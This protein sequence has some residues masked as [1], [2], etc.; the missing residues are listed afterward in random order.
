MDYRDAFVMVPSSFVP[1]TRENR[2]V[3]VVE[4]L[5]IAAGVGYLDLHEL[6]DACVLRDLNCG[7]DIHATYSAELLL[8]GKMSVLTT[9]YPG[10]NMDRVM[11]I[12]GSSKYFWI[13]SD[14]K[15]GFCPAVVKDGQAYHVPTVIVDKIEPI[16]ILESA[17]KGNLRSFCEGL[18]IASKCVV[19]GLEIM[20]RQ[21]DHPIGYAEFPFETSSSPNSIAHGTEFRLGTC[22][23]D[24]HVVFPYDDLQA[25]LPL[26]FGEHIILGKCATRKDWRVVDVISHRRE[27]LL[28]ILKGKVRCDPF[29]PPLLYSISSTFS[30]SRNL[31]AFL[32]CTR[33][34]LLDGVQFDGEVDESVKQK[35]IRMFPTAHF[36]LAKVYGRQI[37]I[38]PQNQACGLV[39]SRFVKVQSIDFS[40]STFQGSND[41]RILTPEDIVSGVYFDDDGQCNG[42]GHYMS[43]SGYSHCGAGQFDK[44]TVYEFYKYMLL[45]GKFKCRSEDVRKRLLSD[46]D[47]VEF[48]QF[49]NRDELW[50][51]Y[52]DSFKVEIK[53]DVSSKLFSVFVESDGGNF[54][55]FYGNLWRNTKSWIYCDKN[56]Y[57]CYVIPRKLDLL[58]DFLCI[59]DQNMR[60]LLSEEEWGNGNSLYYVCPSLLSKYFVPVMFRSSKDSDAVYF[61]GKSFP[62]SV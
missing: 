15:G 48:R 13:R 28:C 18:M 35:L 14:G 25:D 44:P 42:M 38:V 58:R 41:E 51:W 30:V 12:G 1:T 37:G 6:I 21:S 34:S 57:H 19:G 49:V 50:S 46:V 9:L 32:N 4:D 43:S 20:F 60:P 56:G 10:L 61:E 40:S 27:V 16:K 55:N 59:P 3:D 8:A 36:N 52:C 33:L 7:Q 39:P 31:T 24:G 17:G 11:P 22:Y 53:F 54:K 62:W 45:S 23:A 26:E 2:Y 29:G 5:A 47:G